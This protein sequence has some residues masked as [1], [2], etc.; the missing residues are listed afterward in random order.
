MATPEFK[1]LEQI[2]TM[3]TPQDLAGKAKLNLGGPYSEITGGPFATLQSIIENDGR[4][5]MSTVDVLAKIGTL[6]TGT[7]APT[8]DDLKKFFDVHSTKGSPAFTSPGDDAFQYVG[9]DGSSK[10]VSNVTEI[11]G[12]QF[13]LPDPNFDILLMCSR[14]PFFNPTTRHTRRIELFLNSMPSTIIQQMV[15]YLDVEFQVT[16]APSTGLPYLSNLRFLLGNADPLTLDGAN[17]AMLDGR[18]TFEKGNEY[19]FAGMEMFTSPQTMVNPTPNFN[20]GGGTSGRYTEILDPFRPFASIESLTINQKGTVGMMSFKTAHLV[21]K[22]HDRSRLAEISDL[23]RPQAYG[24]VTVWLTYG[25]RAPALAMNDPAGVPYFDFINNNMMMREAYGVSNASFSFDQVGQVIINL[26]LF[27]KGGHEIKNIPITESLDTTGKETATSVMKKIRLLSEEIARYRKRLKLD[28]PEGIN[29]EIRAYQ[30]LDAASS[31]EFPDL[32]AT[33]VEAAIT[34]LAASLKNSANIDTDAVKSLITSLK[35]LYKK[36]QDQTKF[37]LKQRINTLA[38]NEVAAKFDEVMTGPDPFLCDSSKKADKSSAKLI[39]EIGRFQGPP[40]GKVTKGRKKIVSFG[41]LFSVFALH[42]IIPSGIADEAQVFFYS[43][44]EQCG[45]VSGHS[46]AEFPID[47]EVFLNQYTDHA[48]RSGGESITI[49]AFLALIVNAQILDN[50]AV[51]YGLRKYYEPYSPGKDAQVDKNKEKDFEGQLSKWAAENGPFKKPA[52]AMLMEMS[53]QRTTTEGQSD[54]LAGLAYS[55][56]D[57][58]AVLDKDVQKA[59]GRRILRIHIY[60]KQVNPYRAASQLLKDESGTHFIEVPSNDYAK[61][62][63]FDQQLGD[64]FFQQAVFEGVQQDAASGKVKLTEFSNARQI[65]D[66]VSKMVPTLTYGANGT[67]IISANLSTKAESLLSTVNMLRSNTIKNAS[68]PNGSGETGVPLRVIP[69]QL[70][71]TTLGC[72][73]AMMNQYYF[74]DFNTGTSIDNIYGCTSLTHTLA[75][76]KFETAW[77]FGYADAYGVFE[78]APNIIKQITQLSAD[79]PKKP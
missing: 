32:K 67:T 14:S 61:Q 49:D 60:D 9:P 10:Q 68:Q 63:V 77:T 66:T 19:D 48:V 3:F 6:T 28:P 5:V 30:I 51:G 44:N 47:M 29:K 18:R 53:H 50:R 2:F 52:I 64:G 31:G 8:K 75:A 54:I 36:D 62:F 79:I 56:K 13:K 20:A 76:G 24:N 58:S 45:P 73:L 21:I 22:L 16:K 15:P 17:K 42:C 23:I 71:M 74:I 72:P 26:E 70:S 41:K 34:Q 35:E 25:W 37:S 7:D 39:E 11:I 65:K 78:G 1:N 59:L 57:S 43:L 40:K 12:A 69:A 55:A 38:T 27:T 46:I 4:G 33:E